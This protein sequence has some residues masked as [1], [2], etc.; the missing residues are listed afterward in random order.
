MSAT[1]DEIASALRWQQSSCRRL[2]SDFYASVL[3]IVINDVEA[4]GVCREAFFGPWRGDLVKLAV[5]LRFLGAVNELVLRGSAPDLAAVWP[6]D[7]TADRGTLEGALIET[8]SAHLAAIRASMQMPVQTNEVARSGV[9]AGG[10]I[11]FATQFGLP[12]RLLEIGAS[13]GLNLVWDQYYYDDRGT[14]WGDPNSPVRFSGPYDGAPSP[15]VGHIEI[16]DRHGCDLRAL[17]LRDADDMTKLRSYI[18]PDQVERLRRLDHA[19]AIA[20]EG[21]PAVDQSSAG[22]WIANMLTQPQPGE[23]TIVYHSIVLPYLSAAERDHVASTITTAGAQA[24]PEAPIGWLSLETGDTSDERA[25]LVLKT[26]P[27]GE[28]RL[29][30][31]AGY[32]GTPVTWY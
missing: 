10:L 17:D 3:R 22:K 2:G 31:K 27:G 30:A 23:A 13:A 15:L 12:L 6:S 1:T 11:A 8:V 20:S 16:L 24:T 26:W 14:H 29:L 4:S 7:P 19:I 25:S 18:W 21:A 28:S 5:P 9:L 32:H